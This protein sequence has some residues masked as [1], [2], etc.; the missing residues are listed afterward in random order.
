MNVNYEKAKLMEIFLEKVKKELP[1]Q[2]KRNRENLKDILE[3]MEDHIWE[4]AYEIS[5]SKNPSLK[6]LEIAIKKMGNPKNIAK[7]FQTELDT[8][9]FI[10]KELWPIYIKRN[11][12]TI[13]F[14][15]IVTIFAFF[16]RTYLY[17]PYTPIIYSFF[18]EFIILFLIGLN[19]I[20]FRFFYFIYLSKEGFLQ[21]DLKPKLSPNFWKNNNQK[22]SKSPINKRFLIIS[23][24]FLVIIGSIINQ[25]G[26]V[27]GNFPFAVFIHT[28]I[29][30]NNFNP[31]ITFKDVMIFMGIILVIRGLVGEK[32]I[33][34]QQI[35]IYFNL[36]SVFCLIG[37]FSSQINLNTSN[38]GALITNF[39][40]FGAILIL[41]IIFFFKFLNLLMLKKR[42]LKY[43]KEEIV[44]QRF[45]NEVSNRKVIF[46]KQ[47]NPKHQKGISDKDLKSIMNK[48]EN[49]KNK[50]QRYL[51]DLESELP[52]WL[53]R[54]EAE[55]IIDDIKDHIKQ[56]LLETTEGSTLTLKNVNQAIEDLGDPKIIAKRYKENSVPKI[57]I[58]SENYPFYKNLSRYIIVILIYF[59]IFFLLYNNSLRPLIS[60]PYTY[61][62]RA[63]TIFQIFFI[64]ITILIILVSM[65]TINLSSF[66]K[67]F[68]K[69]DEHKNRKI[70]IPYKIIS[71]IFIISSGLFLMFFDIQDFSY[72]LK[73]TLIGT[74]SLIFG[75]NLLARFL[76]KRKFKFL[77]F[78]ITIIN[79]IIAPV[80]LRFLQ[81]GPYGLFRNYTINS[82]VEYAIPLIFLGSLYELIKLVNFKDFLQYDYKIMR[83]FHRIGLKVRNKIIDK[84]IYF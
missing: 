17:F 51:K 66:N 65:R 70:F 73:R 49:L 62:L 83:D 53:N 33:L 81:R 54:N 15:F 44:I 8:P 42:F 45:F 21:E 36:N 2:I 31:I 79:L 41:I 56:K 63:N 27:T 52:L 47:T 24:I 40:I 11:K 12:H 10:S 60:N 75:L 38:S 55:K 16:Y 76:L 9:F 72:H 25:I 64:S 59:H 32:S 84:N 7:Q 29:T 34:S 61:L 4:T 1:H 18:I 71:I 67:I 3:E 22:K 23:G 80:F 20:F 26:I 13:I 39:F 68:L 78:L 46:Q 74:I 77:H 57:Y 43:K 6:E 50:I 19:I 48:N 28:N 82:Y 5:E 69:I 35:L 58:T 30:N 37:M 14:L